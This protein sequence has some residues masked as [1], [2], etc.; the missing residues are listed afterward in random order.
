MTIDYAGEPAGPTVGS[1]RIA[2]WAKRW[3]KSTRAFAP[4]SGGARLFALR[5]KSLV[6]SLPHLIQI[7]FFRSYFAGSMFSA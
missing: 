1:H 6:M 7:T 2:V 4:R 5:C 3:T